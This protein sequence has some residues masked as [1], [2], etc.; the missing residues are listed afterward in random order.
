M[1]GLLHFKQNTMSRDDGDLF[2][3]MVETVRSFVAEGHDVFDA[4]AEF[5]GEVDARLDTE[6]HA[7]LE[8]DLVAGDE[9]GRLVSVE[10]NAV[11]Q[12]VIE[13]FAVTCRRYDIAGY[14]VQALT[15]HTGPSGLSSG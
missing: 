2:G 13:K 4:H 5:A 11:A 8:G 10:A 7:W 12:A 9:V 3:G 6:G 14:G 15:G 1:V